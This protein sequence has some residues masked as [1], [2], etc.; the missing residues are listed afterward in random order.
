MPAAFGTGDPETRDLIPGVELGR[1]TRHHSMCY[2]AGSQS[3]RQS[4]IRGWR[5]RDGVNGT[6]ESPKMMT[7]RMTS[8]MGQARAGKTQE[9]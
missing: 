6:R 4:P 9:G 5:P 8:L 2:D 7:L 1:E 3:A